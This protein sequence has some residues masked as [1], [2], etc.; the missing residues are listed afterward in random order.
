[1]KIKITAVR[2]RELL[3]YDKETGDKVLLPMI[4]QIMRD[5]AKRYGMKP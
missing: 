1:M 4:D 5:E 3:S 2:V